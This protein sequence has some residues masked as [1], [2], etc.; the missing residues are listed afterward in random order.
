MNKFTTRV[1]LHHANHD[2]YDTLHTA[3]GKLKFHRTILDTNTNIRYHLPTAEYNSH[4]D[5]SL[6][7]VL[8]LAEKAAASTGKKYSII[9]TQSGGRLW[10]G[11]PPAV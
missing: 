4:G 8:N 2:D 3:M 11:L 1:E 7:A 10:T 9:V 6:N 5:I